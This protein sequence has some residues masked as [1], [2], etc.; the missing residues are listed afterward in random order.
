MVI[1]HEKFTYE[2]TIDALRQFV[3]EMP[4]EEGQKFA[5]I[6][7]NASWHRKAKRLIKE[8]DQYKDL[9]EKIEFVEIPPYSPD[10]NPIEQLWRKMRYELTDNRYFGSMEI[11]KSALWHYFRRL[12]WE[13]NRKE[14][15]SL[16]TFDF[17]KPPSNRK[18]RRRVRIGDD[19]IILSSETAIA[20]PMKPLLPEL[21]PAS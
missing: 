15:A 14:V 4:L 6:M 12:N 18:P 2:T 11:L 1:Q 21:R 13:V 10:L 5:I 8:D 3:K 9:R 20:L 19:F 16:C 17:D 7:D